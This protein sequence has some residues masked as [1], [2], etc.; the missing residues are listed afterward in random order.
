[1]A[2]FVYDHVMAQY[3]DY[4]ANPHHSHRQHNGTQHPHSA[5]QPASSS[6]A[7]APTLAGHSP[8]QP[9]GHIRPFK[10]A[11]FGHGLALRCLMRHV[12]ACESKVLRFPF[13][14][15]ALTELHFDQEDGWR[16]MSINRTTHLHD[17]LI[18]AIGSATAAEK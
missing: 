7:T 3:K 13:D 11:I 2:K 18:N 15:T 17:P 6:G 10:V 5:L 16:V 12:L 4:L 8:A 9:H 14:N 1:M